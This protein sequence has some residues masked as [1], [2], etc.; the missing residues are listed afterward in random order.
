MVCCLLVAGAIATS[1]ADAL[2]KTLFAPAINYSAGTY[3]YSVASADLNGDQ[4]LDIVVA[5]CL[6][7]NLTVFRRMPDGTFAVD[8]VLSSDAEPVSVCLVD[9]NED[10]YKDLAV[11]LFGCSWISVYLNDGHGEFLP[12]VNYS[13][14]LHPYCVVAGDFNADGHKDLAV[15]NHG[16]GT[17]STLLGS[18]SGSFTIESPV[19]VN[20]QPTSLCAAD[21]DGDGDLDLAVA[22]WGSDNV[23]ILR[24]DGN[25]AFSRTGD[26]GTRSHPECVDVGDFDGDGDQDLV[27]A[28][29]YSGCVSIL[30][31]LGNGTFSSPTDYNVA[32]EPIYVVSSDLNRD[33]RLD[34]AVASV[35][36]NRVSTFWGTA[37][38]TFTIGGT[39]GV[40]RSPVAICASDLGND[41]DIDLITANDSSNNIS[42]LTNLLSQKPSA[43]IVLSPIGGCIVS[44]SMPVLWAGNSIGVG[45]D[46]MEYFFQTFSDSL[47]TNAVTSSLGVSQGL[48]STSYR[49]SPS[50]QEYGHY[51]WRVR[52]FDLYEYSPWS[53]V[54]NFWV[55]D[56]VLPSAVTG[57]SIADEI[58]THIKDH[59]PRFV[60]T[61]ELGVDRSQIQ[62]DISV[63]SDTNWTIAEMW[64]PGSI[65]STDTF[66]TYAGAPLIDGVSYYVRIRVNNGYAW[67][68]YY[69]SSFHMN[70]VP[71]APIPR[72]PIAGKITNGLTPDLVLSNSAD[73]END[74]IHYD[75]EVYSDSLLTAKVA[76]INGVIEAQDSTVWPLATS[77]LENQPYYW[78]ARAYDGYEYSA[79]SP[80]ANFWADAVPEAPTAPGL[81]FPPDSNLLPV[82][83]LMPTCRWSTSNDSDPLDTVHYKLELSLNSIFQG[84]IVY[85]S[86]YSDT[87]RIPD[88]LEY[89]TRYWWRVRAVDRTG[90]ATSSIVSKSFWTW[91]LGDINHSHMSDL[92]DLSALVSYLTGGGYL[93]SPRMVG[94]LNGDCRI[95]LSDLSR[96][97]SYLTGGGAVLR[98]GC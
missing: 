41:G 53:T 93:V 91:T 46:T 82:F 50:L 21:F 10:G 94:D 89:G 48:D 40:G 16:S 59:S 4:K 26:Y 30:T 98:V 87:L 34:L 92:S 23:S 56:S 79:W 1:C 95:D 47:L 42:I 96:L 65:V 8:T 39:Y 58:P 29:R 22:N 68:S 49:V 37:G 18:G 27:V 86:I 81:L 11:A 74:T 70:S 71:T 88:S 78:R 73:A 13:T 25:G 75:F 7:N 19:N 61:C 69:Y 97:V 3:S 80:P 43:P 66:V 2:S 17:V 76:N 85:D 12:K 14:G 32:G 9:I 62:F 51:W 44:D 28:N 31:N 57:L 6:G 60:W 24:N 54:T 45:N 33:G 67:S 52:S 35:L 5:N 84:G 63:G 72:N 77:L 36:T 38:G 20:V 64:N 90:L 55:R 15:A 83:N